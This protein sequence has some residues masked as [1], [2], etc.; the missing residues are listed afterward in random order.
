[1]RF[2]HVKLYRECG[3]EVVFTHEGRLLSIIPCGDLLCKPVL[4]ERLAL[5][6]SVNPPNNEVQN[7]LPF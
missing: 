1:M 4:Q 5:S 6:A 3:C 2:P 7:E